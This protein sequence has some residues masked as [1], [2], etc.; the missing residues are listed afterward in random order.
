MFPTWPAKSEMAKRPKKKDVEHS[1]QAP[2]GGAM[3][4]KLVSSGKRESLRA[5]EGPKR[6][7]LRAWTLVN[8]RSCLARVRDIRSTIKS[9]SFGLQSKIG[10][11]WNGT[12]NPNL[13]ETNSSLLVALICL[14]GSN[15]WI[16]IGP[17]TSAKVCDLLPAISFRSGELITKTSS[18]KLDGSHYFRSLG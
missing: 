2:E 6:S 17:S 8:S 15:P 3:F 4:A 5:C 1:P 7:M 16:L 9:E 14:T 10:L 11:S 18:A 13:E 12:E